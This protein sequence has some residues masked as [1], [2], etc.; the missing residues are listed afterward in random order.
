MADEKT[1][2]DERITWR[3]GDIKPDKKPAKTLA[4]LDDEHAEDGGEPLV[5]S[6]GPTVHIFLPEE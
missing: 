6:D 2:I 4:D 1:S 3:P 5:E